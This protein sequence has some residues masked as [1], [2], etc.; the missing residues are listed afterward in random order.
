MKWFPIY[1][2]PFLRETEELT[3]AQLGA[4]M[5]LMVWTML[6]EA[7]L[8]SLTACFRA[9]GAK[10]GSETK[11]VKELLDRFFEQTERGWAH[12][13]ALGQVRAYHDKVQAGRN[14]RGLAAE[15]HDI[16]SATAA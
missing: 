16:V 4:Y 5:R 15:P 3:M 6:Y 2:R 9:A 10:R 8:P 11:I 1:L 12:S 7:P 13:G 14:K